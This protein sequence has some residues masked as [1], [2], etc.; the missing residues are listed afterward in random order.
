MQQ[1]TGRKP[2]NLAKRTKPIETIVIPVETIVKP[3]EPIVKP[4]RKPQNLFGDA[5]PVDTASK[6]RMIEEKLFKLNTLV[7]YDIISS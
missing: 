6:E 2:L 1:A 7:N 3:I 4:E 5:K